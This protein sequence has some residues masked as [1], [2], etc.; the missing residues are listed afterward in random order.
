[1]QSPFPTLDEL[2][3]TDNTVRAQHS[4]SVSTHA[5]FTELADALSKQTAFSKP[6][7]AHREGTPPFPEY[8][9]APN[10]ED[11]PDLD[12]LRAEAEAIRLQAIQDAERIR[13]QALREGYQRGY[14]QGYADGEQDAQQQ[15]DEALQRTVA[16]LRAQV[17]QVIQSVQA[18]YHEYLQHAETQMLELVLEIA[19]KIVR[20]ELKLQ[21][22]HALAIVRDVLRRVHGFV[23][24]RIRV[25]PLDLELIRQNRAALLHIVD[26]VEGIEIVEDRRVDPGGCII[27]TEHGI[28]D[29]RIKT[30]LGELERVMREVA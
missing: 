17:E 7:S 18:Q 30:Q 19:R 9:P 27:E 15:V 23:Q 22:E 2:R 6:P 1:M 21:P 8:R 5:R 25:N 14:E 4:T 26:G 11:A 3:H 16:D 12:A 24:I 10:N 28:Y 20:E 29:A 13:E